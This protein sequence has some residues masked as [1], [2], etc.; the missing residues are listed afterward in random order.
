MQSEKVVETVVAKPPR[1]VVSEVVLNRTRKE[2]FIRGF[3][4]DAL[5]ALAPRFAWDGDDVIDATT[6]FDLRQDL[7][8]NPGEC[9]DPA[10]GY[11]F[12]LP[13]PKGKPPFLGRVFLEIDGVLRAARGVTISPETTDFDA[14]FSVESIDITALGQTLRVRG[15]VV[16]VGQP[17]LDGVVID[18]RRLALQ[19]AARFLPARKANAG[20]SQKVEL[21]LPLRFAEAGLFFQVF[22]RPKSK[23]TLTFRRPSTL[24][25]F[26]VVH[27]M[28]VTVPAA[29]FGQINALR[30][31]PTN[32]HLEVS[33][34][35][36]GHF[37]AAR[38]RVLV[39]GVEQRRTA[40][41]QPQQV[42]GL[43]LERASDARFC[44]WVWCDAVT[45]QPGRPVVVEARLV[46][47]L[48]VVADAVLSVPAAN[49][50]QIDEPLSPSYH[51]SALRDPF[52]AMLAAA[53]AASADPT[54]AFVFPGDMSR[55][56]GGG[57]TRLLAMAQYLRTMGFRTVLLDRASGANPTVERVPSVAAA[58]DIRLGVPESSLDQMCVLCL[59]E[60]GLGDTSQVISEALGQALS[61]PRPDNAEDLISRRTDHRFDAVAAFLLSRLNPDVVIASFVWTAGALAL[62]PPSVCRILDTVDIQYR[63]GELHAAMFGDDSMQSDRTVELAAWAV[64][65][66]LIAIQ[67]DE[68]DEIISASGR[69]NVVLCG[70]GAKAVAEPR[71]SE[72][73]PVVLF[74]GNNYAP[75]LEGIARFIRDAWPALRAQVPDARLWVV[76]TV[77]DTLTNAPPGVEIL[78]RVDDLQ[79]VYDQA[80]VVI[81]PV[82]VGT[83]VSIKL[84][85]A[86]CNGR[87]TVT[88]SVGIR[89]MRGAEEAVIVAEMPQMAEV[90]GGLLQSPERRRVL[91]AAA[92]HFARR[93]LSSEVVFRELFNTIEL[94]MYS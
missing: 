46:D 38:V 57:P 66:Y 85:E 56:F 44:K 45:L 32:A 3:A 50:P 93:T 20:A 91:E 63:R 69:N 86:L 1:L 16:G 24:Y 2:A 47:G 65:D 23:I 82:D 89:G 15:R 71:T 41:V 92:T 19:P 6:A 8:K 37:A 13:L 72:P 25:T 40:T 10:C 54:I 21:L 74:I 67:P 52:D 94:R 76:G 59:D 5:A 83:G 53:G 68:K 87:A 31:A 55:A 33:G 17:E 61:E 73:A 35:F 49:L 29:G 77:G 36:Y 64:A 4:H 79:A 75:N 27:E 48:G 9:P 62:M 90:V 34:A 14:D 18:G 60:A 84:I 58:F 30:Y 11:S 26:D 39:N 28:P 43:G 78:G 81:N 42:A 70:H 7:L 51:V 22:V 80:A 88:T 12:R